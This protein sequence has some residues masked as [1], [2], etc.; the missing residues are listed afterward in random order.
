MRTMSSDQ[1]AA[2]AAGNVQPAYLVALD[3]VSGWKYF[4]TGIGVLVWNGQDWEGTGEL[5][6]ISD[7]TQTD[8]L[9][10]ENITV[11]L[12]GIPSTEVTTALSECTNS[13][14]GQVYLG[15]LADD[16][17]LVVDPTRC[18]TGRIDVP[19]IEDDGT[20]AT[21]SLTIENELVALQRASNRRWTNDDQ[22]ID[23]P[24]DNGFQFVPFIQDLS[25]VWGKGGRGLGLPF[26]GQFILP[27]HHPS[28]HNID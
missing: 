24:T 27:G 1:L 14:E 16:G 12:S 9:S 11:S 10:A 7:I 5:G 2:L 19:T 3:L 8:D 18:F 13:G 6:A 26:F 4:W 17:S 23:F 21:V 22:H 15:L 20:T 28:K 25:S